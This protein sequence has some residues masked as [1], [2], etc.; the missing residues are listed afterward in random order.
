MAVPWSTSDTLWGLLVGLSVVVAYNVVTLSGV[1]VSSFGPVLSAL[2]LFAILLVANAWTTGWAWAFSLRKY[3][4]GLSAWG[5]VRPLPA[6]FWLVPVALGLSFVV[7]FVHV[8][9]VD[10]PSLSLPSW[11]LDT[12]VGLTV[13]FVTTCL[14]APLCEEVFFR[15]FVFYGLAGSMGWLWAAIVSS[16][17][18][19]AL[20]AQPYSLVP[21]FAQGLLLCWV[22]R[23]GG[24]IWGAVTVHFV[25]NFLA[26]VIAVGVR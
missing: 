11:L 12:H 1:H 21:L 16:A 20:H 25:N 10:P 18:F 22:R 8:A 3:N 14:L 19:A 9:V 24:S 2:A 13:V 17:V 7:R 23:S 4:L 5:F 6:T 26:F 15:G